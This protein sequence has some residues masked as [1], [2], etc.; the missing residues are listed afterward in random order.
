MKELK[1][2]IQLNGLYKYAGVK[3]QRYYA[4]APFYIVR[5]L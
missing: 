3:N 5:V 1:K 2:K 4:V